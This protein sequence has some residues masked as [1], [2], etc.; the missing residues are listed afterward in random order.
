MPDKI[1]SYFS[2]L[3]GRKICSGYGLTETSP[4]ISAD[5]EDV[6][7][8]TN[9]VGKPVIGLQCVAK[10]EQGNDVPRGEVGELWV[11]GDNVMLGY[12]NAP[13]ATADT[14]HDGWLKTGDLVYFDAQGKIVISGRIKDLIIHKGFN[15]YPQEVE[16]VL[17]S[18]ANVLRAAVIGRMDDEHG[19]T[20]IAYVQLRQ[21]QEG[22]E[23]ELKKLCMQ[24]LA[25]YKIPR[26]FI[27]V[28]K[29]LPTTATGKINKKALRAA[30]ET[31]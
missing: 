25:S 5:L 6:L 20:P 24:N 26:E 30:Y 13:E 10:D 8:S 9:T 11:K 3:Y 23:R 2:L 19:E 21:A 28:T 16:N 1:R 4:M 22:I 27:C 31:K 29:D 18:H 15:I 14:M 17:I 12:Y 7:V